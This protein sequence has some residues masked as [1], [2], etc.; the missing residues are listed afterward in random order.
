MRGEDALNNVLKGL[1]SFDPS[2]ANKK[3]M[4]VVIVKLVK[5]R[6]GWRWKG[7]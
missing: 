3:K 7:G 5:K 6:G 1:Q 2:G 4:L